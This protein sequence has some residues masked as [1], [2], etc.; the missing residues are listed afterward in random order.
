[1]TPE[2]NNRKLCPFLGVYC[3]QE[4]CTM[5]VTMHV[6]KASPLGVGLPEA[7]SMCVFQAQL[8]ATNR[9]QPQPV[10]ANIPGLSM[11]QG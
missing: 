4:K 1:M 3:V 5:W 11:G 10:R 8:I 9:P 6:V 7:M 2:E